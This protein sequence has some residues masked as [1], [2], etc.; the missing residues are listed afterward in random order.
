KESAP[1]D[2]L[3][4]AIGAMCNIA[5]VIK[6]RD[7]WNLHA[8]LVVGGVDPD[9]HALC[10]HRTNV[11]SAPAALPASTP[12]PAQSMPCFISAAAPAI[13]RAAA[14]LSSAMSRRGPG[15]PPKMSRR[16]AAASSELPTCKS[17]SRA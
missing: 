9:Y 16:A 14:A 3:L 7:S 1:H 4:Y 5:R 12:C 11:S 15:L 8:L 13:T 17:E 10:E 2:V 6:W